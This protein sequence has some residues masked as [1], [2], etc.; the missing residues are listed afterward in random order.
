MTKIIEVISITECFHFTPVN[1][2][3]I[4]IKVNGLDKKKTST[5]NGIPPEILVENYDIIS[6][7]IAKMYND[8]NLNMFFLDALKLADIT[9]THKKDDTTNKEN[10]RPVSILPSVSKIF[11]RNMLDQISICIDKYLSP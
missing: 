7:F 6:P 9:P 8:S 3:S 10:Y 1:E 2:E 4:S 11:K 5:L